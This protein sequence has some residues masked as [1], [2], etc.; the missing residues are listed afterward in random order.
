MISADG[1]GAKGIDASEYRARV[2][3]PF[4]SVA[5]V[6]ANEFFGGDPRARMIQVIFI[7]RIQMPA[8]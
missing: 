1:P 4:C 6:P 3:L 7:K 2:P 8:A 5:P